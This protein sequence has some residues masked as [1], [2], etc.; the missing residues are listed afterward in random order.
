MSENQ[1]QVMCCTLDCLQEQLASLPFSPVFITGYASPHLDLN[2]VVQTIKSAYPAAKMLL[3]SSAGELCGVDGKTLYCDAPERWDNVVLQVFGSE[4]LQ[5]VEVVSIP[6]ECQDLKQG[7]VAFCMNERVERIRRNIE[8]AQLSLSIDYRDTLAYILFD[9]LSAS[10]SFFLDALYSSGKFPCLFVGGSAGGKFDFKNTWVH[11]GSQ[12]LEG[13][14]SIAF[15]KFAPTLRFGIFKSQN[16]EDKGTIFRV[17]SGSTELRYIDTVVQAGDATPVT[18]IEALCRTFSCN[19]GELDQKMAD[20]TFAIRTSGEVFVRSVARFDYA[21]GRTYFY[22]DI[23]P[24]EEIILVKRLSLKSRTAE[25]FKQ[26]LRDKPGLPVAGWL[27]DCILRRLFNQKELPQMAE[28][29]QSVPVIGFSTFGEV[30]GLNL[31]QTLT[32]IFFFRVE[33]GKTFHDTYVDQFVFYYSNFKS[34]FLQR[35]L[36]GIAG[37]V[38][39]MAYTITGEAQEQKQIVGE[40]ISI[41]QATATKMTDM[42]QSI[43]EMRAASEGLQKIVRMISG[44]AA[45]TN[46]LSLNATIEAARAGEHGRGF[47][48]VADEVRQLAAKSK[49]NAEQI[50]DNLKRF[51]GNVAQITGEIQSQMGLIQQFQTLFQRIEG[52]TEHAQSTAQNAQDISSNLRTMVTSLNDKKRA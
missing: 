29:F 11:D 50:G 25:D 8:R 32:A 40:A 31:N 34:F 9:G 10:E 28:V 51:S 2:R 21:Q 30:L 12:L 7:R 16:F 38:E 47:S 36:Q 45:Q 48:V 22:C 6:L 33:P 20:Y 39:K 5:A 24:G 4:I 27:N 43:E 46:L 26:F 42:V 14:A 44:I 1:M 13:H 41:A 49:S 15:L 19:S 23:A 37:I 52:Q 3:C 17:D 18:L 35:R